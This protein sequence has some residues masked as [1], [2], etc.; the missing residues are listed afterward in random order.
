MRF[1][2]LMDPPERLN[3]AGDTTLATIEEAARRGHAG[4]RAEIS[5]LEIIGGELLCGREPVAGFDAVFQRKDP[6]FD[7]EYVFSTLLLERVRGKT[8]L[9][10]DPRGLRDANEKLFIFEFPG[11]Y[12]ETVVTRDA[13]TLREQLDRFGGE[14]IVK[15]L[16]GNGGRGVFHLTPGD[17]NVHSIFE[18][19]LEGRKWVMAQRYLPA[20]REGDKRIL[21]VAGE[22][23]AALL[24][25]PA[26]DET[27]ANLHVGGRAEAVALSARDREICAALAPRLERDG[28]VFVGID[29]IGEYLTEINVTSPT[30][31]REIERLGGP[32]VHAVL[33]D[34]VERSAGVPRRSD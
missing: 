1:L 29:V 34:W 33:L 13:R 18:T 25:V 3:P 31:V 2:F 16:D 17:R 19:L 12:P 8:L 26:P 28:L 27:R 24:R 23:I 11:L 22:P 4:V 10:N 5:A 32:K 14:M 30:G 7:A 15:P 9:V 21:I 6:P 20:V